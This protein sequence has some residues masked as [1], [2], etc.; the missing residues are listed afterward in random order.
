MPIWNFL[1]FV[2]ENGVN[3]IEG[4]LWSLPLKARVRINARIRYLAACRA[5]TRPYTGKL[6]G[7]CAGLYEIVVEVDNVQYRPLFSYGPG[8][9]EI[10]L[11]FGAR[12]IGGKFEPLAACDIAHARLRLVTQQGRACEHSFAEP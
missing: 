7:N 1:D 12:E 8:K 10:T 11:L 5:L 2:D 4:W 3:V 6:S 9:N